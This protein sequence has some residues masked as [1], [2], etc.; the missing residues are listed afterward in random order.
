M[1]IKRL[2]V[3][4]LTLASLA[5]CDSG[6]PTDYEYRTIVVNSPYS[7]WKSSREPAVAAA[8]AEFSA[9]ARSECRHTI[10]NGWSLFGV[11]QDGEINCEQTREGHHCR[12]KNV[13]LE[14]RQISEFF[15]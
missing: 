4:G 12:K 2:G 15:P 7:G 10:T 9:F 1:F 8:Q 11:K 6:D 5:S 13:E 3:I 14:C